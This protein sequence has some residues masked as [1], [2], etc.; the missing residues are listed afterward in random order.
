M[1]SREFKPPRS[2]RDELNFILHKSHYCAQ[3]K[4]EPSLQLKPYFGIV[5]V[6]HLH[7]PT[8]DRIV[9]FGEAGQANPAASATGLTRMLHTYKELATAIRRCLEEN[10]LTSKDLLR[11][12]PPYMTRMNRV[13]QESFFESLLSFNSDDFR[14]LI[15]DMKDYPDHIVNDLLF[16]EFDFGSADAL[17]L[18]ADALLR[19]RRVLGRQMLNSLTR[20]CLRRGRC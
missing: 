1:P 5:P 4:S 11:A 16:A 17:Q 18:A 20:F 14:R 9:F 10:R 13:F 7:R 3:I 19:P 8:L 15:Q 2:I 12:I 6:G